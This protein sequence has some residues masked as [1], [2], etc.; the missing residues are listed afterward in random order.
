ML[1]G[2]RSLG[3]Y[4]HSQQLLI[5]YIKPFTTCRTITSRLQPPRLAGGIE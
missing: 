2:G 4:R 5:T 1:L 3:I